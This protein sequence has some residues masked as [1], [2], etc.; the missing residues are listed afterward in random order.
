M[1]G[2][3]VAPRSSPMGTVPSP[4]PAGPAGED[5]G[6]TQR[7]PPPVKVRFARRDQHELL[8]LSHNH[9]RDLISQLGTILLKA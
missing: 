9:F 3:V 7:V 2:F 1:V 5:A 4:L 8:R 6:A